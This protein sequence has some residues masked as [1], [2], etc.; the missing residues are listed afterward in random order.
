MN[1]VFH[2][3]NN[4]HNLSN[5][6]KRKG[7]HKKDSTSKRPKVVDPEM[8]LPEES[9]MDNNIKDLLQTEDDK[10]S[11]TSNSETEKIDNMLVALTNE[12]EDQDMRG[13]SIN[14]KLAMCINK[15]WANHSRKRNIL[16]SSK[17]NLYLPM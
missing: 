8:S 3:S 1:P 6:G 2:L 12:V 17:S 16:K 15:I 4:P 10:E 11:S 5:S 13:P 9:D 7:K 14:E